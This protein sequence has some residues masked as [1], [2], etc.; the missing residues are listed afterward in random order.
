M[1]YNAK[2]SLTTTMP[3]T[4]IKKLAQGG[5]AKSASCIK[6]LLPLSPVVAAR[7]GMRRSSLLHL[8]PLRSLL[9]LRKQ[10]K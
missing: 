1:L 3:F 4:N 2:I 10:G 9:V 7:E 6:D 5:L 8:P